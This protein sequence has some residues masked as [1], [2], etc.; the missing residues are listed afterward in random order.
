[1]GK[2]LSSGRGERAPSPQEMSKLDLSVPM[3]TEESKRPGVGPEPGTYAQQKR[4]NVAGTWWTKGKGRD[5][6]CRSVM[7]GEGR[8]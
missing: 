6:K 5:P 2:L 3:P 1:M 7:G 4:A 8:V